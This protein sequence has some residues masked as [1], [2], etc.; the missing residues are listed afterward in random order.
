MFAVDELKRKLEE[1]RAACDWQGTLRFVEEKLNSVSESAKAKVELY[2]AAGFAYCQLGLYQEAI[3]FYELWKELAPKSAAARYCL[4][5]AYAQMKR[6]PEAIAWFDQ[7]LKLHPKYIVCLYRK[8]VALLEWGKPKLASRCFEEALQAYA[9]ASEDVRRANQKYLVK[10]T[11]D[12]GKAYSQCR[13]L[14]D[15]VRMFQWI[16]EHDAKGYLDRHFVHYNLGKAYLDLNE[17]ALAE[18]QLQLALKDHEDKEYVW[19]RL[20]YLAH[21]R[22][23]YPQALQHYQRA[24][25]CRYVPYVLV[26]RAETHVAMGNISLAVKDLL[27]AL[28]RD[29]LGKHK[30][31]IRLAELALMQKREDLAESNY[32]KAIDFKRKMYGTDCAQARYALAQ[33]YFR[34]G[35]KDEA[36]EELRQAVLANPNLSWDHKIFR[37]LGLPLPLP[38]M[39]FEAVQDEAERSETP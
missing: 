10:S 38:G 15:A 37:A 9:E 27:E 12:L 25:D 4:G 11:F 19:E 17:L 35:K 16:L 39:R 29:R 22:Q 31:W 34:Q 20:G 7:A 33:L 8:G 6:Y 32:R 2:R 13:R 14:K 5:Y 1:L 23:D 28:R 30:I 18:E 21:R 3:G 24:L 36:R 26:S